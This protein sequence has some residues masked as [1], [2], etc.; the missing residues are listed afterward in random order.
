MEIIRLFPAIKE[1][2]PLPP[3]HTPSPSLHF[4]IARVKHSSQLLLL[5]QLST[6]VLHFAFDGGGEERN[7]M[8]EK[9][10]ETAGKVERGEGSRMVRRWR[11][12]RS[13]TEKVVETTFVGSFSSTKGGLYERGASHRPYTCVRLIFRSGAPILRYRNALCKPNS[14]DYKCD[15]ITPFVSHAVPSCLLIRV[16]LSLEMNISEWPERLRTAYWHEVIFLNCARLS[17]L[18]GISRRLIKDI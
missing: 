2:S 14:N 9:K 17:E 1:A 6:R 11:M 18:R 16:S 10:E 5:L 12:T 8:K 3:H 13:E 7:F 4:N 15:D